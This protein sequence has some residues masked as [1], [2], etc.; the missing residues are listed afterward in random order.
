MATRSFALR[1]HA[2]L[3][4][5]RC[6][7][8][9]QG[10]RCET[11]GA[12]VAVTGL[13]VLIAHLLT[14]PAAH[15]EALGAS[16]SE[17]QPSPEVAFALIV[18]VNKSVDPDLPVLRYADDDA[19]R[20]RDLFRSVGTRT[21]LLTRL[22]EN[23]QRLAED[24]AEIAPP[25]RL[26]L[27]EA[28]AAVALEVAAAHA[29]GQ[30]AIFYFVYAGHGNVDGAASEVGDQG[31]LALE[32]GRLTA[33][34]IEKAVLDRIGAD[35]SHVL[36]DACYSYFLAYGR[37]P[38]GKRR[39]LHGFVPSSGLAQRPDVGLLLSTTSARQSHEWEGFQAGVFSHE[40]RSGLFGAA[41][42]D[43]DGRIS[44]REMAAFVE[45]ANAA[46][47]NEKFRPTVFSR[48]PRSNG[49]LL[50]LH[51][52]ATRAL[53]VGADAPVAH[54]FLEDARGIRVVDFHN[55]PG[56][57]VSIL[58]PAVG[59]LYV[60][61]TSD[62]QELVIAEGSDDVRLA[63]LQPS[64]PRVATR[65]A[66]HDAFNLI[67]SLP[68]DD[69]AWRVA[70]A[71]PSLAAWEGLVEDTATAPPKP[72]VDDRA[73]SSFFT[74]RRMGWGALGIGGVSSLVALG[75]GW[76]TWQA[77]RNAADSHEQA[78]REMWNDR[79]T[80]REHW[81]IATSAVAVA[82][83]AG[84]SWLLW[85]TRHDLA[86]AANGGGTFASVMLSGRF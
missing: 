85:S 28:V 15:A 67:F 26:E 7:H 16:P 25:R 44:Y 23:T 42:F 66:A 8:R 31:Y 49:D 83:L 12:R 73:P 71:V 75:L 11:A 29:Q 54:Y 1:H 62:D 34:E 77:Q 80:S 24:S 60:R 33:G 6:R 43:G 47:R 65:G 68:F 63:D 38:G 76:A 79:M 17:P 46:I 3:S 78:T 74:A 59:T 39:E 50:D 70:P 22:D 86:I 32:D 14:V 45:R 10:S 64:A 40:V 41:D 69:E 36:V 58:I 51:R 35:Q 21:H 72:A 52:R 2:A 19:V 55:A 48:P 20:Y 9:R 53:L 30:R 27:Q 4:L 81:T 84:G 37:G 56:R 57:A 61:R 82:G 5:A 18:G 13:V